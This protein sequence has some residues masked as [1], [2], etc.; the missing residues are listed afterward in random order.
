MSGLPP[1]ATEPRT[2]LVVRFV[3]KPEVTAEPGIDVIGR[4][5]CYFLELPKANRCVAVNQFAA[6]FDHPANFGCNFPVDV[7][8]EAPTM[9]LSDPKRTAMALAHGLV[10]LSTR[11]N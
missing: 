4:S 7:S 2:S 1:I 10:F 5:P 9:R 6:R 8:A 11:P 3:P